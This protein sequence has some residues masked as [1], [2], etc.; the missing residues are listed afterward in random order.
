MPQLA[1]DAMNNNDG[2]LH[3]VTP[4]TLHD[5]D[6][7]FSFNPEN[8]GGSYISVQHS[9]KLSQLAKAVNGYTVALWILWNTFPDK[10]AVLMVKGGSKTD[11]TFAVYLDIDSSGKT[12]LRFSQKVKYH[13]KRWC[14]G[15]GGDKCAKDDSGERVYTIEKDITER[16][17]PGRWMHIAA[18]FNKKS[19]EE[20][21]SIC[22][23][24]ECTAKDPK[25]PGT[26][27][28]GA[29]KCQ[30]WAI[31]N[32]MDYSKSDLLIGM[33]PNGNGQFSGK[34]EDLQ[35][36]FENLNHTDIMKMYQTGRDKDLFFRPKNTKAN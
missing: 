23:D 8:K 17:V 24:G 34:M 19:H 25:R 35:I 15:I 5:G 28:C 12:M 33:A 9:G 13:R 3:G 20:T 21:M 2:F 18:V 31:L 11:A 14:Y 29:Y 1:L 6:G 22:A 32:V 7:V 26:Y 36:I 4:E 10:G 27:S 30:E 16:L